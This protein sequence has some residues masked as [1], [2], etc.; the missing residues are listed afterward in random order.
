M[1]MRY[2]HLAPE[3]LPRQLTRPGVSWPK[4]SVGRLSMPSRADPDSAR[5]RHKMLRS[6]TNVAQALDEPL[7]QLAEHL[8]FNQ[9]VGGSIPPRLTNPPTDCNTYLT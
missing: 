3:N 1:V 8:T 2:A 4:S 7:A 5:S 6:T 9:G